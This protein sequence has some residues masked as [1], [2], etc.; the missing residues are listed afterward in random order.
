MI[1]RTGHAIHIHSSRSDFLFERG[2]ERAPR[3]SAGVPGTDVE[4][5]GVNPVLEPRQGESNI[6]EARTRPG[7]H[8]VVPVRRVALR[9][10]REGG[11]EGGHRCVVV[12]NESEAP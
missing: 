12:A 1:E 4:I 10:F 7:V 9:G 3:A 11:S 5:G 8:R 2:A 6:E